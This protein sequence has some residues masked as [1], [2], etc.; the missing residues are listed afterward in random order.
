[1]ADKHIISAL[2]ENR[3]GV[4]THIAGLFASRGF[5]IDSLAVGETETPDLSRITVVVRGDEGILEQVRK[6]LDKVIDVIRV[7]ELSSVD[8]VERDLML[9]NVNAPAGKRSE[10]L[11]VTEVFRGK[12]VD[13]GA[14]HVMIEI[15]GPENKIEA[16][17]ELM[18]PYGIRE[19]VRTGRVALVRGSDGANRR[20]P[21]P[22]GEE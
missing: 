5:N 16:F 14:R 19:M 21:K 6:Q 18:R 15:S 10:I 9:I 12:I 3:P 1:M 17:I 7:T 2:V 22:A 20:R 4:L 11:E 13:I 8:H